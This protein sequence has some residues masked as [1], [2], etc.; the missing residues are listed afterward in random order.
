MTLVEVLSH[1]F[2]LVIFDL[3]P[4]AGSSAA[5]PIMSS[6]ER[7]RDGGSVGESSVADRAQ[8]ARERNWPAPTLTCW[9]P[10]STSIVL[11]FRDSSPSFSFPANVDYPNSIRMRRTFNC[12]ILPGQ[13]R[14]ILSAEQFHQVCFST[15]DCGATA[16]GLAFCM[17]EIEAD[18]GNAILKSCP[19]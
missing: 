8:E 19:R 18:W 9:A 6:L 1:G 2:D 17:I 12:R 7:A 15:S 10:S 14:V 5:L 16:V 3:P 4:V 11:I 13:A